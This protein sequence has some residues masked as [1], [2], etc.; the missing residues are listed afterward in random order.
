MNGLDKFIE[1][2]STGTVLSLDIFDTAISRNVA[3][4]MHL[5]AVMQDKLIKR[6][7]GRRGRAL[8]RNF[9]KERIVAE[10]ESRF[11]NGNHLPETTL[12]KIY[13]KLIQN[14]PALSSFAAEIK[15]VEIQTEIEECFP[16]PEI[17]R[18]YATA[19]AKNIP[20]IFTSDMYLPPT[21]IR[22]MLEK[23]G[24]VKYQYLFLSTE[25]QKTKNSGELWDFVKSK[26]LP[27]KCIYHI[28]DNRTADI[29]SARE[30]D[31][32]TFHFDKYTNRTKHYQEFTDAIIPLSRLQATWYNARQPSGVAPASC[33]SANEKFL[34]DTPL[35]EIAS[36]HISLLLG[37]F[38]RWISEQVQVHNARTI[39]F[40]SRDGWILKRAWE[41]LAQKG[42]VPM[43]ITAHY[44]QISRR[45][46]WVPALCNVDDDALHEF[47]ISGAETNRPVRVFLERIGLEIDE[48]IRQK[49]GVFFRS[50]DELI[51]G[52]SYNSIS[53]KKLL[54]SLEPEIS[55][56]AERERG[57]AL[58]Y[59]RQAGLLP[60]REKAV[61]VD[62]GWHASMQRKLLDLLSTQDAHA[63]DN[64]IGL[65]GALFRKAFHNIYRAGYAQG[66]FFTPFGDSDEQREIQTTIQFLETLHMAPHGSVSGY[67]K[68]P[69]GQFIAKLTENAGE[70]K[71][72]ED[73]IRPMQET[74]LHA[75]K[76]GLDDGSILW[77]DLT[78]QV[79]LE[80]WRD[81]ALYPSIRSVQALRLLRHWDGV[82][83]TGEGMLLIP[84]KKPS[85]PK[86]ALR[87][88]RSAIWPSGLLTAWISDNIF[89]AKIFRSIIRDTTCFREDTK[90]YFKN[91]AALHAKK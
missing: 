75:L 33:P 58:G 1:E 63:K 10:H 65:Y 86:E 50:P 61:L 16:V 42:F 20:V 13:N 87:L 32:T 55:I 72:F 76:Q 69:D 53:L 57:K 67:A 84:D 68:N 4:P 51:Q 6:Y 9:A 25:H 19:L 34:A 21:T 79:Y 27:G 74:A 15:D 80:T 77:N 43:N 17:R 64:L 78:P 54:R 5:F 73:Y 29:E 66:M 44:T 30:R 35:V 60:S 18:V 91:L 62:L 8:F 28:G 31:I 40:L 56:I 81:M 3:T 22:A 85:S 88:L 49:I 46:L 52:Q 11:E 89:S 71:I 83:H 26:L 48:K 47:L 41:L 14:N 70:S 23:C 59:L 82:E 2:I 7:D 45:A 39:H 38:T 24:Y 36:T 90:F 12:D 37:C